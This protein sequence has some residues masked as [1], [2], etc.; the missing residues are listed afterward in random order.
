MRPI[1]RAVRLFSRERGLWKY[2][3]RP[4]LWGVLAY[5]FVLALIGKTGA[6]LGEIVSGWLGGS[7]Q[8]GSL[9]G[10]I[11]GFGVAIALSGAIYLALVGFISG[12]GFDKLSHEVEERAFGRA[13]G[14]SPGF[15]AGLSDSIGRAVMAGVLG[16]VALCGAGTVVIPWLVAS[17]L[18]LMD[19][20]APALLRRGVGLGR[21]FGIARRL[22]D[23]WGFALIAGALILIPV[24]NVLALPILVTAAT[25]IVAEASVAQPA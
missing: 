7:A 13:V 3:V 6:W 10:A 14:T 9:L 8:T 1:L 23:A 24:V 19:F 12:F 25:L 2:A 16:I 18:C 22:P 15:A 17:F 5:A 11:V 21:Q 4:M 20:T